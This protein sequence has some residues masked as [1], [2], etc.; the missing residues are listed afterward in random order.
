MSN[1]SPLDRIVEG[2]AELVRGDRGTWVDL[3]SAILESA[4][5]AVEERSAGPT[6]P[7]R[8][9]VL[10]APGAMPSRDVE[11]ITGHLSQ[12]VEAAAAES[13]WRL[14]GPVAVMLD[15]APVP[16][17]VEVRH[18]FEPGSLAPWAV[19]RSAEGQDRHPVRHNRSVVGR[20]READVVIGDPSVSRRHALLWREMGGH[21]IADF[22]SANGSFVNGEPV[23]DVV[24]VADADLIRFGEATF[25]VEIP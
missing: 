17:V 24:E 16:G 18:A 22:T 19:L 10:M 23:F 2:I 9:R 13:G 15:E 6:V 21:W 14:E 20:S 8:F 25:V 1:G 3:G 7:N 5:Q 4:Q 12:L 11:E